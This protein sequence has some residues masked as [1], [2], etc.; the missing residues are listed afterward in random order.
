MCQL[1]QAQ[2]H[3]SDHIPKKLFQACYFLKKK[4]IKRISEIYAKWSFNHKSEEK[5]SKVQERA[6]K[7]SKEWTSTEKNKK[8]IKIH[9]HSENE[10]S[11]VNKVIIYVTFPPRFIFKR[12]I[13]SDEIS[14]FKKKRYKFSIK[15][16][17]T[18]EEFLKFFHLMTSDHKAIIDIKKQ[19]KAIWNLKIQMI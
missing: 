15:I 11:Q 8:C 5:I 12:Y 14:Q 13:L 18:V 4:Y 17:E 2:G 6:S 19:F 10:A 7:Y 1:S 9:N 16:I 3:L